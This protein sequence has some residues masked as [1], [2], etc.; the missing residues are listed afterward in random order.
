MPYRQAV[1]GKIQKREYNERKQVAQSQYG[2]DHTFISLRNKTSN[3][4]SPNLDPFA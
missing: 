1:S 2:S 3:T 4:N